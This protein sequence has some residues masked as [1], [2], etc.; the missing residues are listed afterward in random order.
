MKEYKIDWVM[1]AKNRMIGKAVCGLALIAVLGTT[2]CGTE[3]SN[4]ASENN[5]QIQTDISKDTNEDAMEAYKTLLQNMNQDSD[6]LLQYCHLIDLDKNGIDELAVL[7]NDNN[8]SL[9]TY[10]DGESQRLTSIKM[11]SVFEED[12]EFSGITYEEYKEQSPVDTDGMG[13]HVMYNPDETAVWV[14]TTLLGDAAT[15]KEYIR[16]S[17]DGTEEK[18]RRF[19]INMAG[20]KDDGL[21]IIYEYL[22]DDKVVDSDTFTKAFQEY[23]NAEYGKDDL[24]SFLQEKEPSHSDGPEFSVEETEPASSDHSDYASV[25]NEYRNVIHGQESIDNAKIDLT[26]SGLQNSPA[27]TSR[28]DDNGFFVKGSGIKYY[29]TQ[30]DLNNDGIEE[31]LIMESYTDMDGKECPLLVDIQ[32]LYNGKVTLVISGEYRNT[33]ELCSDGIIKRT[34]NGGA[35]SNVYEFYKL[36]NGSIKLVQ[37]AEEDQGKYKIDGEASTESE[38]NDVVSSYTP[39]DLSTFSWSEL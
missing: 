7:S 9:Y 20:E 1:S 37:T 28:I 23:K 30:T 22:I 33:I 6:T 13:L 10:K 32:T 19:N 11:D 17:Y 31:L 2:A 15:D 35:L 12:W 24:V 36:D 5:Q 27:G 26:D 39:V 4:G 38:V 18:E 14:E 3:Q 16:V 21:T 34:G 8:F 25:I 29:Y